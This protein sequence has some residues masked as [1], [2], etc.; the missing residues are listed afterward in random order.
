LLAPISILDGQVSKLNSRVGNVGIGNSSLSSWVGSESKLH[1]QAFVGNCRVNRQLQ[2]VSR[3]ILTGKQRKRDPE[4][5]YV[6]FV[7]TTVKLE[8]D[9]LSVLVRQQIDGTTS[10]AV[11]VSMWFSSSHPDGNCSPSFID[12]K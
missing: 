1:K 7:V 5:T 11:I 2:E 9:I 3:H 12:T 6:A 8:N 10:S 4:K